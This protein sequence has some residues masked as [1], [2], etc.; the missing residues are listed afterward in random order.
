MLYHF[1]FIGAFGTEIAII[2]LSFTISG[3]VIETVFFS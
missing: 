3:L 1:F 2:L